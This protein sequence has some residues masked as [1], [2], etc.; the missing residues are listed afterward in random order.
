MV[1]IEELS[2]Y[3]LGTVDGTIKKKMPGKLFFYHLR[4]RK[5]F[6]PRGIAIFH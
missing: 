5:Y 2:P 3:R 1:Q 4:V 6:V